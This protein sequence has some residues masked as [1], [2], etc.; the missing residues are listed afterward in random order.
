METTILTCDQ[1]SMMDKVDQMKDSLDEYMK[2]RGEPMKV[3]Y[4][5]NPFRKQGQSLFILKGLLAELEADLARRK[6]EVDNVKISLLKREVKHW[7]DQANEL[8]KK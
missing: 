8:S 1:K 6:Q 2:E 4:S 3:P 7:Q 5:E